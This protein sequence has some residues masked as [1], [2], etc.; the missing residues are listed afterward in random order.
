MKFIRPKIKYYDIEDP[1]SHITMYR[2]IASNEDEVYCLAK[3]S[4]FDISN[5]EIKAVDD[6]EYRNG[7]NGEYGPKI[8]KVY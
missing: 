6:K 3:E 5:L 7:N 2:A 1:Q 4:N 8:E